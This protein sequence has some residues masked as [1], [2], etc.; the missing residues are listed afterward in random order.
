MRIA[1]RTPF[2][3][4][5]GQIDTPG[6]LQGTL[7]Y[8]LGWYPRMQAE[9]AVVAVLNKSLGSNYILLRNI[10][11]P[12]T[13]IDLPLVLLGPPGIYVINVA[14]E[15]GVF[16]VRDDEWGKMSGEIFVPARINLV[17]RTVK[18]GRVLQL[19]LDRAGYKGLII[20]PVL[21]AADPGIH[22]DTTRPAA[23]IVLYDALERFAV[24]MSQASPILN[25]DRIAEIGLAIAKGSKKPV[26]TG[27]EAAV[28]IVNPVRPTQEP[29]Q[30]LTPPAQEQPFTPAFTTNSLDFSF[31]DKQDDQQ[32]PF[33]SDV[34]PETAKSPGQQPTIRQT[35][36]PEGSDQDYNSFFAN[37]S[38]VF[39]SDEPE[40]TAQPEAGNNEPAQSE[41]QLASAD[42]Q[43]VSAPK[44]KNLLGMSMAQLLILGGI[45]IFWC[46][47]MAGFIYYI[48]R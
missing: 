45:L 9:D 33:L 30:K 4:S 19:Y 34:H 26:S 13:D 15:R 17:Q 41:H 27:K 7:K 1:D 2:R 21:M 25:T 11:L 48:N 20:E 31:D 10:T 40:P 44:K 24:S 37:P 8:G 16:I 6:R 39:I 35:P 38:Q 36:G 18:L 28:T 32:A 42:Y 3:N 22:I 5:S 47:I 14:Y 12:N 23:R 43:S 29:T 46:C